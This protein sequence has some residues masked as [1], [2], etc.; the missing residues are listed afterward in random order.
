MIGGLKRYKRQ[1]PLLLDR[2]EQMSDFFLQILACDPHATGVA[3][4]FLS[5]V[6]ARVAGL[7]KDLSCRWQRSSTFGINVFSSDG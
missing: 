6:A 5:V 3:A 1:S 4:Q 7:R 2:R